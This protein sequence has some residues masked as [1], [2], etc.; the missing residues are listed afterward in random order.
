MKPWTSKYDIRRYDPLTDL[1]R[2][3]QDAPELQVALIIMHGR[4]GEDGAMQGFLDLLEIPYQGSGVLASALAMNKE[5]SKALYQMAGLKVPDALAFTGRAPSPQEIEATLGLPVVIKPAT[6]GSSIGI[7]LA[8]TLT[9]L[10]A[11]WP[12][13]FASTPRCW[14]RSSS[15]APRLPAPFWAMA[16]PRPCPWWR[17]S[18]PT[19]HLFRLRSQVPARGQ[20]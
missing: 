12:R 3:V 19:V 6:E 8:R 9:E 17:S 18:P 20:Q 5:L 10:E 7:T 13:P 1:G 2:L 15:R 14:W 11:A 4:G 16:P